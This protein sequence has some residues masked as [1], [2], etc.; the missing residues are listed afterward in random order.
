MNTEQQIEKK[1]KQLERAKREGL[2]SK[3]PADILKSVPDVD[4][5]LA[6]CEEHAGSVQGAR[7]VARSVKWP[8]R[9]AWVFGVGAGAALTISW[10]D[11]SPSP[12]PWKASWTA[13]SASLFVILVSALAPAPMVALCG[14]WCLPLSWSV[15]L[16]GAARRSL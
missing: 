7:A 1:A 2:L 12:F 6:W 15:G 4:A 13:M 8:A 10:I 5:A 11:N 9:D 16:P 3:N 14:C